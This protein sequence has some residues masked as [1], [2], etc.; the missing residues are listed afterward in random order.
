MQVEKY[1]FC[2]NKYGISTEDNNKITEDTKIKVANPRGLIIMGRSDK[3]SDD[4][5]TDF[6]IIKR[7][8]KHITDIM[9][10]DDLLNRLKVIIEQ[11]KHN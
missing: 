11:L 3:F 5:K 4:Q 8:Y 9:T 7:K 1:I 6:E 10:Y 2:L